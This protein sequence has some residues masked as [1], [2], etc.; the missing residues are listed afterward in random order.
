[1]QPIPVKTPLHDGIEHD[2]IEHDGIE[3]DGIGCSSTQIAVI[4]QRQKKQT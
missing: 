3:H 2:G 1:M 4:M